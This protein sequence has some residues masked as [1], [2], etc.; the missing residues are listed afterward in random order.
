MNNI[1]QQLESFLTITLADNPSSIIVVAVSGG[2]DSIA[3]LHL[4]VG[5]QVKLGYSLH[6]ATFD[7]G[8]RGQQSAE[9]AQV[10]AAFANTLG[11]PCTIGIAPSGASATEATARRLRYEFLERVAHQ[12]GSSIVALGHHL[13]D[14]AETLLLRLVRGAGGQGLQAM[15]AVTA[16]P[17]NPEIKLIRPL[18]TIMRVDLEAYCQL[19]QLPIRH[20]PTNDDATYRRNQLRLQIIPQ[21]RAMNPQLDRTLARTAE[22]LADENDFLESHIAQ[23]M[24]GALRVLPNGTLKF[25]LAVFEGQHLAIKRR[26]LRQLIHHFD[27]LAEVGF[28]RIQ[29]ALAYWQTTQH[30]G[31]IELGEGIHLQL[32]YTQLYLG[33]EA[34]LVERPIP[35]LTEGMSITLRLNSPVELNDTIW[36]LSDRKL[37]SPHGT[38]LPTMSGQ[39][40]VIRTKREGDRWYPQQLKGHSKP[41]K[42]WFSEQRIPIAWRDCL[43]LIVINDR[44]IGII[45]DNQFIPSWFISDSSG[46]LHDDSLYLTYQTKL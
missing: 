19:H 34:S 17:T 33:R 5:L 8:W 15:K 38:M 9:D 12:V 7:H 26:L 1:I 46:H 37:S 28:E 22:L 21:L 24:H 31:L 36:T 6:V 29:T 42:K 3:L 25:P 13:N 4:M 35:F 20:D 14:Q 11:I 16:L 2:I 30:F 23:L 10:V 18:L 27:P 41:L 45:I 43:P 39:T 40:V 44:V 32:T